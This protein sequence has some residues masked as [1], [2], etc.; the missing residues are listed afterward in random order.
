MVC[1]KCGSS[2]VTVQVVQETSLE[3]HRHSLV[4]WVLVGWWWLPFKWVYFTG[5]ALIAKLFFRR[6]T[7]KQ[8]T[9]SK[10]VCQECGHTWDAKR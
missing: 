5:I 7:L 4:W 1:E 10:F 6:K 8:R 3:K 2:N 9:V